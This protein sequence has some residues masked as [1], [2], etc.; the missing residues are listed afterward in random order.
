M[1]TLI[2]NEFGPT[3]MVLRNADKASIPF[4]SDNIDYQRFKVDLANGVE[5]SDAEGNPMTADQI[6]T[7]LEGLA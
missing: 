1:Y 6:K 7:F 3:V 5:L 4:Y 2:H